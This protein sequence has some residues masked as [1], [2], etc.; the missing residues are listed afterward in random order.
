[1]LLVST[2]YYRQKKAGSGAG[3][4]ASEA[5]SAFGFSA[6][7]IYSA[8]E[9]TMTTLGTYQRVVIKG[10]SI[11]AEQW[12]TGFWTVAGTPP[13]TQAQL[14][15][16]CSAIAAFVSTWWTAVKAGVYN[17]FSLTEVD[18][19][20]YVS[21]SV[22]ASLQA[23]TILSA[24][25]GTLAAAG[26]SIDQACVC[27]VR[28]STPGRSG[29]NRL[30]VPCHTAVSNVNGCFSSAINNTIGTATKALFTSVAGYS[31]YVPVVL[32]RTKNQWYQPTGFNTDNKPDV[33]RRR[34]NR[35]A[36]TAT[37]VLTFP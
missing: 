5:S 27:S 23:Q 6:R 37:Q 33:Q 24:V 9:G 34:E 36:A 15:T 18:M 20:Q 4:S 32:S 1:M 12:Q 22:T 11:G 28:S 16:D 14:S 13:T 21:P 31:T 35:L 7:A 30:Y 25:A 19:Y 10:T 26:P 8:L 29:R 17:S 2:W 3:D